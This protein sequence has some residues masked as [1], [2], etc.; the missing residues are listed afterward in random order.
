VFQ[1]LLLLSFC[2]SRQL[3][4][5]FVQI[6]AVLNFTRHFSLLPVIR[7]PLVSVIP[8]MIYANLFRKSFFGGLF[9]FNLPHSCDSLR[10]HFSQGAKQTNGRQQQINKDNLNGETRDQKKIKF[11][12][13]RIESKGH[14]HLLKIKRARGKIAGNAM[15]SRTFSRESMPLCIS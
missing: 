10:N 8:T 11:I 7:H 13:P 2:F 14:R 6:S 12:C 9:L 3:L 1:K 5:N 4:G 15:T